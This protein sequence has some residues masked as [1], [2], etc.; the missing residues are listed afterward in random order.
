MAL[1]RSLSIITLFTLLTIAIPGCL[2]VKA[3]EQKPPTEDQA[4]SP[5]PEVIMG[6]EPVR[7]PEGDM[8]ALLPQGWLYL[9]TKDQVSA[10]VMIVAVNPEYTLSAVFSKLPP[11]ASSKETL[12]KEGLL[13]LARMSYNT[14]SRKTAGAAKLVGTYAVTEFGV[15]QFGTYEFTGTGSL[16]TRCAVFT[17]TLGH[18]YEFAL[19][20]MSVA[21]RD[22]PPDAIQ[23]QVF[24]SI[25]ATIQY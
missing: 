22:V 7:A 25:L 20:P 11:T 17:S 8:I 16:R 10:D 13:G 18:A 24:R 21:G 14:H 6:D 19:V 2:W 5:L 15:R 12:E 23:Q 4:L 1:S 9:D 3:P